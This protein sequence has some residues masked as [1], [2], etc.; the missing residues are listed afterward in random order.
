MITFIYLTFLGIIAL[1]IAIQTAALVKIVF[2][3]K[4][5]NEK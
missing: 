2:F 5:E 4:G 3:R 1:S